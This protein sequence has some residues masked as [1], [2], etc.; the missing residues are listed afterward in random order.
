MVN[1]REIPNVW[2]DSLN[3]V[4]KLSDA[5]M[6]VKR[7]K[8]LVY[9]MTSSF[10]P[11]TLNV[12]CVACF[13]CSRTAEYRFS[14]FRIFVFSKQPSRETKRASESQTVDGRK[15]RVMKLLITLRDGV[16]AAFARWRF[17]TRL[18]RNST[19]ELS[20]RLCVHA[21]NAIYRW[22]D[23]DLFSPKGC[24]SMCVRVYT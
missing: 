2:N 21:V 24:E 4:L 9:Q 15:P 5:V 11:G 12:S 8:D 19:G 16:R 23:E 22:E 7:W 18:Y 17:T 10:S 14:F 1:K 20:K 13:S 3:S 6:I